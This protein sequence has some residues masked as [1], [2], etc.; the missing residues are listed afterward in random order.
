MLG[1]RGGEDMY[2]F[3]NAPVLVELCARAGISDRE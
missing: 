2:I 1:G 3:I